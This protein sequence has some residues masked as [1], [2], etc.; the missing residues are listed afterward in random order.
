MREI[1]NKSNLL[2][3]WSQNLSSLLFLVLRQ[4]NPS[5]HVL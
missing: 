2:K 4:V 1:I 3:N 5:V